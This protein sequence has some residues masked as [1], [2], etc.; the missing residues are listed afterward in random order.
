[1]KEQIEKFIQKGKLQRF[2]K[3]G[4]HNRSRDGDKDK[5]EALPRDEDCTPQLLPSVIGEIKMITGGPSTRGLFKSL[6]KSYQR[7]VNSIL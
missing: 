7:Q 5:R 2:V 6:K 1:M 4:E 3:K